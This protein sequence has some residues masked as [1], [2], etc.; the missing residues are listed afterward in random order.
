MIEIVGMKCETR[1]Q[2][3]A[4][5]IGACIF[6]VVLFGIGYWL[7]GIT[8]IDGAELVGGRRTKR[9]MR[10]AEF[11]VYIGYFLSFA[12]SLFFTIMSVINLYRF[13]TNTGLKDPDV[14]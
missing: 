11:Y 5:A 14:W 9:T 4:L 3:I 7:Y 8:Q 2:Q 13:A 1:E 10:R 6:A 12:G